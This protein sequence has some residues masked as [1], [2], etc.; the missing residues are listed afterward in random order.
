MTK[1]GDNERQKRIG[2]GVVGMGRIAKAH[3]RAVE[4]HSKSARVVAVS[5]R[6]PGKPEVK[7][8]S[9]DVAVCRTVQELVR[10][11]DV[12]AVI[13][14]TPNHVRWEPIETVASGG[15]HILVEKPIALSESEAAA[16]VDYCNKAG[17]M[18]MVGQSRRFPEAVRKARTM[19]GQLGKLR[20]LDIDFLVRFPHPPT[21]WWTHAGE[22]GELI[23]H[24]QASHSLDTLAW[25]LDGF[26]ERVYCQGAKSN[27]VFN[28]LDEADVVLCYPN[29]VL[30][31]V[32][33]SLNTA[34]GRHVLN[35]YGDEG[36]LTLTEI[37]GEAAFSFGYELRRD[38]KLVFEE[39][40]SPVYA[41][42]L[43]EFVDSIRQSRVPLASGKEVLKSTRILDAAVSSYR[44][45]APIRLA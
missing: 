30:A 3:I 39:S 28:G 9:P 6:N 29:G 5:T 23:L 16:M 4:E 14:C 32:S 34:P 24:L 15:K 2:I 19:L 42:Q 18:L 44:R 45:G 13:V 31:T 20:R 25:F 8:L 43:K 26:P 17:V 40:E 35:A 22:A 10:H 7:D 27:P 38:G 11:P 41:N 12:D 21:E 33:L 37:P 36:T 1:T